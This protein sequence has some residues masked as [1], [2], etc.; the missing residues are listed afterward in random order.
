MIV[1]LLFVVIDV[2]RRRYHVELL[3]WLAIAILIFIK[4]PWTAYPDRHLLPTYLYQIVLVL[5]GGALAISPLISA[6]RNAHERNHHFDL[7]EGDQ[8]PPSPTPQLPT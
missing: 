6:I 1:A 8:T 5:G 2:V 3:V 4:I 7:I